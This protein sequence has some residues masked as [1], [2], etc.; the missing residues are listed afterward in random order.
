ML[1]AIIFDMDGV[2]CD[3]E[4]SHMRAF[5]KVLEDEGI[6]LLDQDYY[7]NYLAYDDRGCFREVFKKIS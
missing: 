4:P 3:S 6:V 2:I 1:R 7:D 5:Q